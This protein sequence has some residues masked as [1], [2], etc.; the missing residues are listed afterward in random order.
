MTSVYGVF[1]KGGNKKM[2]DFILFIDLMV[3]HF[4]RNLNDVLLML[5]ISDDERNEL[6]V[7][8]KQT[9]EILIPPSHTQQK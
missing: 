3:T 6:S 1:K 8:Y 2:K 5:P 7:L 4:N 9:K